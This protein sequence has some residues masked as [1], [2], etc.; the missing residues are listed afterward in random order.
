MADDTAGVDPVGVEDVR[1]YIGL[2]APDDGPALQLATDAANAFVIRY[3]GERSTWT[4]DLKLGAVMQAAGLYRRRNTS[5]GV[6]LFGEAAAYTRATDSE[7]ERM[8][9]I[10]RY[11]PARVG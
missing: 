7:V 1:A 4:A 3:K 9:R 6:E 11:A 8:L 2:D 5:G 10:G